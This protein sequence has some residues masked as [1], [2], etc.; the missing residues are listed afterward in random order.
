MTVSLSSTE[1]LSDLRYGEDE[2]AEPEAVQKRC[3]HKA[4]VKSIYLFY[5][6]FPFSFYNVCIVKTSI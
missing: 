3:E 2:S 6:S 4:G 1:A 5:L